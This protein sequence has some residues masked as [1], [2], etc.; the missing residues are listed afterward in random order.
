LR[1]EDEYE[2]VASCCPSKDS[3]KIDFMSRHCILAPSSFPCDRREQHTAGKWDKVSL[4]GD[5]CRHQLC[6]R[7]AGCEF[8]SDPTA[9]PSDVAEDDFQTPQMQRTSCFNE[10]I[11]TVSLADFLDAPAG[12]TSNIRV[13]QILKLDACLFANAICTEF[14]SERI[15]IPNTKNK[16]RLSA[17]VALPF[18]EWGKTGTKKKEVRPRRT[19]KNQKKTMPL[20]EP[21]IDTWP[22]GGG[23]AEPSHTAPDGREPLRNDADCGN[24]NT[25]P[26]TDRRLALHMTL[27]TAPPHTGAELRAPAPTWEEQPQFRMLAKNCRGLKSADRFDELMED[28]NQE[29]W[30]IVLLSETW[31]TEVEEFY[32]TED[33]HVFGAA[34][35]GSGRRGVGI[36]LHQRWCKQVIAFTPVSERLDSVSSMCESMAKHTVSCLYTSQTV[37]IRMQKCKNFTTCWMRPVMTQERRDTDV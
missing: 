21:L 5:I 4:H 30:D 33:D 28:L 20:Y 25:R 12:P 6:I 3:T 2:E 11:L 26:V 29:S 31:R 24:T 13:G 19:E 16:K 23:A 36:L 15:E 37:P 35:Y 7:A 34:G 27:G 9:C 1:R 8:S 22:Q 10:E 14:D 17:A 32:V 18:K